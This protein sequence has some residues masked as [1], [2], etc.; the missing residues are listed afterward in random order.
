MKVYLLKDED[1]EK[2]IDKLERD[3]N[4]NRGHSEE[5]K[6]NLEEAFRYYNFHFRRWIDEVTK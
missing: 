6:R 2:L 4:R 5:E 1:F 3:P